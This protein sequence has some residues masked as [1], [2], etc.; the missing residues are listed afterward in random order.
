MLFACLTQAAR[1]KSPLKRT[2]TGSFVPGQRWQSGEF[3]AQ[4]RLQRVEWTAASESLLEGTDLC[5]TI[6]AEAAST[7]RSTHRQPTL[8]TE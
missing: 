6:G 2:L 8:T 7:F 5:L 4:E 1:V 3:F